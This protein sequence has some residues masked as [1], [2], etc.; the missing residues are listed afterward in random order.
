MT[1]RGDAIKSKEESSLDADALAGCLS[2]HSA[3]IVD[4]EEITEINKMIQ[5]Y[6]H[7]A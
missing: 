3:S 4:D 1:E 2:S 6:D 5:A 7:Q